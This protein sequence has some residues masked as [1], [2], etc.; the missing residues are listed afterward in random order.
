MELWKLLNEL[1]FINGE[2]ADCIENNESINY[3]LKRDRKRLIIKLTK[4]LSL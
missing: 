4:M 1:K 2:I 3:K